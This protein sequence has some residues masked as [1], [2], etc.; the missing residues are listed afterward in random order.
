MRQCEAMEL[1]CFVS[2]AFYPQCMDL[3][4]KVCAP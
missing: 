3:M 2:A 1:R 4:M